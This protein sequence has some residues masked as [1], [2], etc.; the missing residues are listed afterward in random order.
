MLAI[1]NLCIRVET[2]PDYQARRMIDLLL[3]GPCAGQ[4][5]TDGQ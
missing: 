5:T 1:G 3:G 2:F 4:P